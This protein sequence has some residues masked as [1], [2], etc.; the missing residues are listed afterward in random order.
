MR[1]HLP[2]TVRDVHIEV[3]ILQHAVSVQCRLGQQVIVSSEVYGMGRDAVAR[4]IID[5]FL[6]GDFTAND[7]TP[8]EG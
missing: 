3:H 8:T 5:Q 6:N 4:T 7:L 2:S 1:K